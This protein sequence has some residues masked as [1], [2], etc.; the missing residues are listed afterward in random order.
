MV[1][2][3]SMILLLAALA[4]H[5]SFPSHIETGRSSAYRPHDGHNRGELA[6]G[7]TFTYTQAHIAYR[8]WWRYGCGRR[9]IVCSGNTGICE[10]TTIQDAGPYG[11]YTGPVRRCVE[12]GRWKVWTKSRPPPGWKWRAVVDLSWGL[13]LKL[14][15]PRALSK[16]TLYILPRWLSKTRKPRRFL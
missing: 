13:W 8:K 10:L 3:Y 6:C 1:Y 5:L 4:L 15:R 9:V 11:I 12:D 7:G 14:G 16:V 2:T